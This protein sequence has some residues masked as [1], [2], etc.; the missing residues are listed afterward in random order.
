MILGLPWTAWLLIF[1]AV[2][3]ALALVLTFYFAH[4]DDRN[5]GPHP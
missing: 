2:V 4:R 5:L 1:A 3:P